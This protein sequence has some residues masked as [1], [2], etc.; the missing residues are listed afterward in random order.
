MPTGN[1]SVTCTTGDASSSSSSC[2]S[3]S[4]SVT[5]AGAS[6]SPS[7]SRCLVI[8]PQQNPA[9]SGR[10]TNP[11]RAKENVCVP[12][13][14]HA[15][16]W[17]DGRASN[18]MGPANRSRFDGQSQEK[19]ERR[20]EEPME[21][22]TCQ[23]DDCPGSPQPP[24]PAEALCTPRGDSITPLPRMSS[25]PMRSPLGSINMNVSSPAAALG[26]PHTA[27]GVK[28]KHSMMPTPARARTP[29]AQTSS[30][31]RGNYDS[32]ATPKWLGP[33]ATSP[34]P[35]IASTNTPTAYFHNIP[36]GAVSGNPSIKAARGRRDQSPSELLTW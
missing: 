1:S 35:R 23:G 19:Q 30:V 12:P 21:S 7:N 13:G 25:R 11:S 4:T 15:T 32:P 26:S 22:E 3:E 24:H 31:T 2:P 14:Q 6:T 9:P 28:S 18:G 17:S 5:L 36:V 16:S 20:S 34:P 10:D 27:A 33:G 8:S 29:M